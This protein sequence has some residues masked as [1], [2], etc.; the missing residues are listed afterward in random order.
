MKRHKATLFAFG[1]T[2]AMAA[3][4]WAA[5]S[6]VV[7][8]PAT[9]NGWFPSTSG[10][11]QTV[12]FEN[13]PG[14]PLCGDGSVELSV[15]PNGSGAAQVRNVDYSGTRL[16]SLTE[17]TYAGYVDQDGSGGQ[18]VYII[19]QLDNDEN[20][21]VDDL[22]FFEPVYQTASFFPSNPQPSIALDTWQTWDALD[23]G[24]WSVNNVAGAGPGTNVKSLSD[25]LAVAPDATIVN[26]ADGA[27]GVRLVAGFG[28]GA[29]DDFIGNADCFAI[30]VNGSTTTYDF[31]L[32]LPDSDGDG[33]PDVDDECPDSDLR[34]FVDVNGSQPGTTS[35]PNTVDDDGC[36]IQDEVD[37]CEAEAKNHGQYVKCVGELAKQLEDDGVITKDQAKEMKTGAAKSNVGK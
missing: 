14:T 26:S 37:H 4:A 36:S 15:G 28:A 35:I 34:P 29:W 10:T 31:E 18:S 2:A 22:I 12:T 5:D 30:G 33:V 16:D 32:E 27:G 20:G 9:L 3:T 13:G 11:G 7:V 8:T 24:W 21:T 23:G 6:T 19:L 1:I 25:Y 17:L